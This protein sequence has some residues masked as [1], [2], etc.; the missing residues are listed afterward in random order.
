MDCVDADDHDCSSMMLPSGSVTY[1]KVTVPTPVTGTDIKP[2][3]PINSNLVTVIY[4]LLFEFEGRI[5]VIVV[6]GQELVEC[7]GFCS[8]G[9][10]NKR[11][12]KQHHCQMAFSEHLYKNRALLQ[13]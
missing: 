7:Q 3:T 2:A 11:K 8:A 4:F 10:N 13:R 1:T 9:S 6:E 5:L 12:R